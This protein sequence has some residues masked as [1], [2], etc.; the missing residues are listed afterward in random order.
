MALSVFDDKACPPDPAEL[1][2]VLGPA[3][4]AWHEL[5]AATTRDHGPLEEVWSFAGPSFGWSLRLKQK[6]RVVLYLTPQAGR[7]LVGMALGEKA[8]AAAGRELPAPVLALLDA[9]PRYAEG[10][11]LRLP[12]VALA[13]LPA[14][15]HLAAAKMRR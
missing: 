13:D 14:V 11:G 12:V 4:S 7:F 6:K 8:V 15:L 10:R 9:A 5:V 2:R 3:A 1:T